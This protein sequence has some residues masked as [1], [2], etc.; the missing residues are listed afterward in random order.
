MLPADAPLVR[1]TAVSVM[2]VFEVSVELALAF[3][4]SLA[5]WRCHSATPSWRGGEGAHLVGTFLSSESRKA[6]RFLAERPA[7]GMC[8]TNCG[9]APR[10]KDQRR[11]RA[12]KEQQRKKSRKNM[13]D[14]SQD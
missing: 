3:A 12:S 7:G 8:V 6:P 11:E 2:P 14:R 5:Q 10:H 9:C 1:L 13:R 4:A